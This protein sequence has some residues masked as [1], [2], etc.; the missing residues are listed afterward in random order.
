MN[1]R[2]AVRDK[3]LLSCW[4]HKLFKA[5]RLDEVTNGGGTGRAPKTDSRFSISKHLIHPECMLSPEFLLFYAFRS[6]ATSFLCT[7]MLC[8]ILL[9]LTQVCSSSRNH[10]SHTL[11]VTVRVIH[12]TH[13]LMCWIL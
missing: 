2:D 11:E 13:R 6:L 9:E 5:T 8:F 12:A 3:Y 10:L 4:Q 1:F 7:Y